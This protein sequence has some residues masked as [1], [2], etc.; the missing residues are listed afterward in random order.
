MS[1][2]WPKLSLLYK[3]V[4]LWRLVVFSPAALSGP[5]VSQYSGS[6]RVLTP[7]TLNAITAA[8]KVGGEVTFI[9]PG[10]SN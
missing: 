3:A 10:W 6:S 7:I 5:E 8:S 2:Q 9:L 4:S 1:T